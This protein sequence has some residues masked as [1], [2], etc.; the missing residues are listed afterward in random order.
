MLRLF[1]KSRPVFLLLIVIF[2]SFS[3]SVDASAKKKR[4]KKSKFNQMITFNARLDLKYD[5]NII[6]YSD[7]DL[8]LYAGGTSESKFSIESEDDWILIPA[9][10]ARIRGKLLKGHTAWL[11][12]NFR[13]YYYAR[14]DIRRYFRLGIAGRHYL[15]R[16]GYVEAEYSFIPDYYYRNQFYRD[17]DGT[18]T[19]LEA[20]FSKH[21]LKFEYGMNLKP[22]LKGDISYRY[23][24]KRFTEEFSERD[25][26]V[27]GLRFDGI[28]TAT[29][30]IKFWGYYGLERAEAKGADIADPDIKDV[31]YDA[32]DITF[33]A[34][35]YSSILE[36]YRTEFVTSFKF[37]QIKYQTIKYVDIY[38]FGRKDNNYYFRVGVAVQ[39]PQKIRMEMDYNL[40]SKRTK[41]ID[42]SVKGL[43]EYDSNSISLKL[44]RSF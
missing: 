28:W 20:N 23:Q 36:K 11:E 6:N 2:V 30:R 21:Y 32:W 9:I 41:I 22:S 29:K 34:R 40:V 1:D 3:I 12:P 31:S 17:E 42:L 8:D 24:N 43:L 7:D 27:N 4:S 35:Y 26:S 19:Y 5:D 10:E 37:R 14:N 18:G 38:R 39:L 44:K 33:G 13:Y 15:F 25:L 16:S